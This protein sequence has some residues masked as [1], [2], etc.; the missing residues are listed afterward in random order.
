MVKHE[1]YKTIIPAD[2]KRELQVTKTKK[3]PL[4]DK[5]GLFCVC[6]NRLLFLLFCF[7]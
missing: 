4:Q 6:Q 3:E 2:G 7:N 5:Q 1:S